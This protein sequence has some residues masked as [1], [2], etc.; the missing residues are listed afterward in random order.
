MP[1]KEFES[2]TRLDDSDINTFLMDQTV[3]SFA[4]TAAR[5]SAIST[6][7]QGMVTYLN[8]I[9]SLSIYNGTQFV[10]NKPIQIFAGTA[11]RGSAIFSPEPGII[12]YL[13]DSKSF[14]YWNGT[15]YVPI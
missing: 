7:V 2:F 11:A 6:P 9:D 15:S 5:G 3:Q 1:R 10:D 13:A 12:T 14:E 8:D 4:G